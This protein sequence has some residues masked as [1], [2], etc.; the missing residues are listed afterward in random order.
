VASTPQFVGDNVVI[1]IVDHEKFAIVDLH[2]IDK[3]GVVRGPLTAPATSLDLDLDPLISQ[4]EESTS[5]VKQF[6]LEGSK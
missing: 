1:R 5:A 2:P 4:L 3:S 6:P